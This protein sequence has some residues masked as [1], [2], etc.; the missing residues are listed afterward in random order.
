MIPPSSALLNPIEPIPVP[1]PLP[2]IVNIDFVPAVIV[3]GE[4]LVIPT[5]SKFLFALLK[6]SIPA[7][8]F[9]QFPYN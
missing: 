2:F 5:A 4:V 6:V 7:S 8:F 1:N 9:L 3:V